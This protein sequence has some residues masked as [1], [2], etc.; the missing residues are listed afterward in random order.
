MC[1]DTGIS[2]EEP[3]P[4]AFFI[5]QPYGARPVC[6]GIGQCTPSIWNRDPGLFEIRKGRVLC[7][8]ERSGCQ[9]I[10]AGGGV[11]KNTKISLDKP[12][13]AL[14]RR[15]NLISCSAW[16]QRDQRFPELGMSDES[17]PDAYT[18]SY[19]G[20]IPMLKRSSSSHSTD[21]LSG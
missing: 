5:Q 18:G 16:R 6:K 4:N 11:R 2:Y 21:V 8:W 14:F 1:E 13:N 7:R 20:I 17:V 19:E 10:P 9:C 3:S 15:I 12:L